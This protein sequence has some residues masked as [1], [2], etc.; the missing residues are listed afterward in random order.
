MNRLSLLIFPLVASV[1][2]ACGN[3]SSRQLQS[4]SIQKT[5]QGSQIQLVATGTFSAAPT[6][7][8]PLPVD[9]PSDCWRPR[10]RNTLIP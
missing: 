5:I 10:R 7:V 1:T 2:V 8:T 4:I 6:T 9:G 3:N